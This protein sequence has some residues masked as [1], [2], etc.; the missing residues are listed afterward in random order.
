LNGWAT[1]AVGALLVGSIA[2]LL[3]CRLPRVRSSLGLIASIA[4]LALV[5]ASSAMVHR[6][7][8]LDCA[9]VTSKNCAAGIAPVTTAETL[10][11]LPEGEA[12]RLR[13][14]H[15]QFALVQSRD[16]RSGWV[17]SGDIGQVLASR[18]E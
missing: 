10:F 16:G 12:V 18:Q 5:T 14:T 6:W 11:T 15:G 7:P 17:K 1:L 2:M 4:A 8:D 13:Q 3:R 9:I